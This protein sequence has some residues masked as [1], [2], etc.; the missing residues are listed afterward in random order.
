MGQSGDAISLFM[1]VL[2]VWYFDKHA[3]LWLI[4]VHPYYQDYMEFI[5]DKGVVG[6]V[7]IET[8]RLKY[9]VFTVNSKTP[10]LN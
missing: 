3:W 10:S 9:V 4:I 1:Y 8:E 2:Y 6:A 7:Q 5:N